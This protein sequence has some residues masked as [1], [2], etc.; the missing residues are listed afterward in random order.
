[1]HTNDFNP[2]R[3]TIF[4]FRRAKHKES[5]DSWKKYYSI[6]Q[7]TAADGLESIGDNLSVLFIF[8]K[9]DPE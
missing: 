1:M 3:K 6:S 5:L 7:T 4:T 9:E 2:M 8:P